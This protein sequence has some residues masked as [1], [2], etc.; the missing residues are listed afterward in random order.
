MSAALHRFQA[1]ATQLEQYPALRHTCVVSSPP[2]VDART[3]G[4]YGLPVG[5][6]PADDVHYTG[7][8]TVQ[9][10][11]EQVKREIERTGLDGI[12]VVR[13]PSKSLAASVVASE[14]SVVATYEGRVRTGRVEKIRDGA[15]FQWVT[16]T[17]E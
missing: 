11:G 14:T 3:Q 5:T 13:L 8:C 2:T 17:W 16:V 1:Y 12:A 6:A 7:A 9:D 4:G 15:A 10:S